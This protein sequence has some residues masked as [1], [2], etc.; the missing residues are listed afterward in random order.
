LENGSWILA[1]IVIRHPA[2]AILICVY[3]W[4]L[5]QTTSNRHASPYVVQ[6][7][8]TFNTLRLPHISYA[9]EEM[10]PGIF[11]IDLSE[12]Q[13]SMRSPKLLTASCLIF[14]SV[15]CSTPAVRQ[16]ET[17]AD[18]QTESDC[19]ISYKT[20]LQKVGDFFT[21]I[22]SD[23]MP[24]TR[25]TVPEELKTFR[26]EALMSSKLIYLTKLGS[27]Y[28]INCELEYDEYRVLLCSTLD[29]NY[30]LRDY[31]FFI[32]GTTDFKQ[33]DTISSVLFTDGGFTVE[34]MH[35]NQEQEPEY[36]TDGIRKFQ[37]SVNEQLQIK[38]RK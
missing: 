4:H 34:Q 31:R 26:K 17:N 28:L 9:A 14:V 1:L 33:S 24:L 13:M 2:N 27:G 16:P 22:E 35:L 32:D 7:S 20:Q 29:Q 21:S 36:E 38:E 18:P 6:L 19:A 12:I 8:P 30:C 10:S 25:S 5:W 23:P 3:L 11:L 15:S 37:F